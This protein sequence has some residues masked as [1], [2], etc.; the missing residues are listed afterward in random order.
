MRELAASI[1]LFLLSVVAASAQTI[2]IGPR[3]EVNAGYRAAV[4]NGNAPA[5]ALAADGAGHGIY[6]YASEGRGWAVRLTERDGRMQFAEGLGLLPVYFGAQ[7]TQV[8]PAATFGADTYLVTWIEGAN[9]TLVGAR[10]SADGTRIDATPFF[11]AAADAQPPA[12]AWDGKAFAIAYSANRQNVFAHVGS[13]GVVIDS[14]IPAAGTQLERNRRA[15]ASNGEQ[16]L[17]VFESTCTG[18]AFLTACEDGTHR[19]LVSFAPSMAAT[20]ELTSSDFSPN[21]PAVASNGSGFLVAQTSRSS[22]FGPFEVHA[23]FTDAAGTVQRDVKLA[24]LQIVGTTD[25]GANLAAAYSGGY[26]FVAWEQFSSAGEHSV[27]VAVLA[28]DGRIVG[29]VS[30]STPDQARERTPQLVSL[31]GGRVLLAYEKLTDATGVGAI[32]GDLSTWY[33]RIVSVKP[34]RFRA[35]RH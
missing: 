26:W 18:S 24:D 6:V 33:T 34:S 20:R 11:I 19:A 22:D 12:I 16:T 13:N 30:P 35:I 32:P 23:T 25:P 3:A 31:G 21:G 27:E 9:T 10:F 14:G 5:A 28:A 29:I 7:T 15:I 1:L 2:A 8:Y 4:V 17:A